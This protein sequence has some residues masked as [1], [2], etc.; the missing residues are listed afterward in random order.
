MFEMV[1]DPVDALVDRLAEQA[2]AE[3]R[4]MADE[5]LKAHGFTQAFINRSRAQK[6]RYERSRHGL[7]A[8]VR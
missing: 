5:A 8:M 3:I 7:A 4:R 1:A 6:R 2:H